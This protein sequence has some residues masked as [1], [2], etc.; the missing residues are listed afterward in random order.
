MKKIKSL[1]MILLVTLTL[2]GC[3]SKETNNTNNNIENVNGNDTQSGTYYKTV[4]VTEYDGNK[5]MQGLSSFGY[6]DGAGEA[7]YSDD[8]VWL[9]RE[10]GN[11]LVLQYDTKTG[12][13]TS[14]TLELY[15][16]KESSA[17]E[18]MTN[19]KGDSELANKIN[20]EKVEKVKDEVY[21]VKAKVDI[22]K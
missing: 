13:C 8:G 9:Y 15:V 10:Y 1:M 14:A 19:M 11:S 22:S 4:K 6:L 3:G 16:T 5:L 2:T 17:N 7:K 18:I 20:N 21:V 12:K